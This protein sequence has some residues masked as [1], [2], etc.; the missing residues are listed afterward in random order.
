VNQGVGDHDGEGK[1]V[2]DGD[3]FWRIRGAGLDGEACEGLEL[4][5]GVPLALCIVRTGT[6]R[7]VVLALVDVVV[8]AVDVFLFLFLFVSARTRGGEAACGAEVELVRALALCPAPSSNAGPVVLVVVAVF[9]SVVDS[10]AAADVDVVAEL[11]VAGTAGAIVPAQVVAVLIR[12]SHE[13]NTRCITCHFKS[14]N[15]L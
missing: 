4:V 10:R 15:H 14:I 9:V 2:G 1:G 7:P 13:T 11:D 5:L 6:V 3:G 12:P 8:A